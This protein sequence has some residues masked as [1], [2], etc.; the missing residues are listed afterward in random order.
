MNAPTIGIDEVR[1]RYGTTPALTVERLVMERG[2]TAVLGPNGSGKST[3]LRLLATLTVPQ[4]GTIRIDGLDPADPI[5]RT[6]IRRRLGYVAQHDGLPSRMRVRDYCDY[7]GALKEIGPARL[8]RRWTTWSLDRLGLSS[9]ADDRIRTLSGGMQRRLTV[10]QALLGRPDLLVLDEPLTSLDAEYRGAVTTMLVERSAETTTIVAT[11]H[12]DELATVCD[13]VVVLDGGHV[14]F[15]GQPDALAAK[16]RGQ[17][18]ETDVADPALPCRAVGPGRFRCVGPVPPPG[19]ELT[20]P[21]V[22]DGY[23]VLVRRR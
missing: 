13:R 9:V 11:H 22:A 3:L 18:W 17:V 12:A 21:S 8:R 1:H 23:L 2:A 20:Q 7:V 6:A 14:I 19:A 16:A 4:V 15:A 5:E 10:A